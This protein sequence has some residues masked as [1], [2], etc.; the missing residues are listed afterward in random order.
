MVN[1]IRKSLKSRKGASM[2][3]YALLVSLIAVASI[4]VIKAVG[5]QLSAKFSSV[6]SA[7]T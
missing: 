5:A 1:Q 4:V 2:V 7:L 6:S 3:E